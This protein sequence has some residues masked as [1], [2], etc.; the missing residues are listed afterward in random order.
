MSDPRPQRVAGVTAFTRETTAATPDAA[1]A[2]DA[3]TR[4]RAPMTLV[5]RLLITVIAVLAVVSTVIGLVSVL[6]LQASLMNRVDT[7][8]ANT[9]KRGYV[10]ADIP[11]GQ[12][13]GGLPDF[14]RLPDAGTILSAPSQAEGT[15]AVVSQDGVVQTAGLL[16]T[17]GDITRIT[18][19][20]GD[21]LAAVPA[22]RQPHTIALSEPLGEYRAIA[23][24]DQDGRKV[25]IGLPL[26]SVNATIT[27]LAVTIAI[28]AVIGIL[29]VAFLGAR[30]VR[31]ALRPLTRVTQTAQRV[32]QLPLDR[33]EVALGERV[34]DADADERTEVGQVGAALNTMLDHVG[35]ALEARQESEQKVR[36][37]VADASHEL[38]TPL[39]SIRGYSELTRRSGQEVPPDTAHALARIESESVRMTGLVEDLLL[40]ARLD[41]GR[42][43][44]HDP[45]DLT[46]IIIDAIGDAHVSGP[47]HDWEV[48]L[49][50]EPVVVDGDA[51]RLHQVVVN[52]LANARVHT[53]AG[54][55]VLARLADDGDSVSITVIDDGPGI[56]PAITG[57]LFERFARGDASRTR[58]T[59]STGLGLAIV[60]AVVE[61]HGGTVSV[62]S[63]PGDTVFTVTI[64]RAV[65]R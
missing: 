63:E 55:R 21:A 29:V 46:S 10:A 16:D 13:G 48:D 34:P 47:D 37:F 51:P 35:A 4:P 23:V 40:L 36:R 49:P 15:V 42:E 62:A 26:A 20:Q 14:N 2:P 44:A 12:N 41:E 33:G 25:V 60:Q 31:I 39:A 30:I 57:T 64:P 11:Q 18:V 65:S 24:A 45:V 8:L 28:V 27:Q 56:D 3:A 32:A 17:D 52:L 19:E 54:T 38:R 6:V 50:E 61:A 9:T 1:P 22:D 43:L 7:Q 53:P 58:A 5:R 59:G